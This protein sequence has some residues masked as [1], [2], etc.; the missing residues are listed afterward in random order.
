MKRHDLVYAFFGAEGE[1]IEDEN[2]EWVKWNDV[3][4]VEKTKEFCEGVCC[5]RDEYNI[6]QVYGKECP[7]CPVDSFMDYYG[8]GEG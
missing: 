4:R 6:F 5:N 8:L 7:N 3:C 2:G 1:M